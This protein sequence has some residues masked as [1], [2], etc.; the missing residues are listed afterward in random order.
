MKSRK[1]F[2]V[3]HTGK[4]GPVRIPLERYRNLEDY[5]PSDRV[6]DIIR[7]AADI[8]ARRE[9][10]KTG[11]CRICNQDSYCQDGT[12][13]TYQCFI[14]YPVGDNGETS[15]KNIWVF[16]TAPESGELEV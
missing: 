15:G 10:G 16:W 7:E 8:V 9:Y 13:S 11:Y 6:S 12:R 14:G 4:G 5:Y 2:D 3:T 1:T